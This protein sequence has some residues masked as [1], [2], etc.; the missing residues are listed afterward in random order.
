M[1]HLH[2][3]VLSLVACCTLVACSNVPVINS[4]TT[5]QQAA[6]A[7]AQQQANLVATRYRLCIG[8]SS[9]QATIAQKIATLPKS[10][11]QELLDASDQMARMC[12]A[13]P[14]NV[15][16]EVATMT[17]SMATITALTAVAVIQSNTAHP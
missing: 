6:Q 16:Q 1:K 5:P 11:A 9:A 2:F 15:Q 3:L 14:S 7:T 8:Y 4:A 17:Q 13:K 12:E 10:Q